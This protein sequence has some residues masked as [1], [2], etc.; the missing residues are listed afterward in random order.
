MNL[1]FGVLLGAVAY[2]YGVPEIPAMIGGTAP[3]GPAWTENIPIGGKVRQFGRD[4]QPYE[5][6]RFEDLMREVIFNGGQQNLSMLI[7]TPDGRDVWYDVQPSTRLKKITK[8]ASLG[9]APLRG[10]E[11]IARTPIASYLDP[12]TDV[13]LADHDKIIAVDGQKLAAGYELTEL[14][15]RHSSS[16][17]KLTVERKEESKDAAGKKVETTKEVQIVLQPRAMRDLGLIMKV[18]PVVAVRKGSP[19]AEAGFQVG[20]VIEMVDGQPVGDPLSLGQRLVPASEPA[21]SVEFTISRSAASG[22]PTQKTLTVTPELPR[23]YTGDMAA[24]GPAAIE[25]VGVAFEVTA[26]VAA[27]VPGSPAAKAGLAAGD[28]LTVAQFIAANDAAREREQKVLG[29]KNAFDPITLDNLTKNWNAVFFRLQDSLPDTRLKLTW[30]R[31]GKTQS[32]ELQSVTSDSF[33]DETRGVALY[34]ER[35]KHLAKNWSEALFL[36]YRETVERLKEVLRVLSGLLTGS[37]SATNL[38]GPIGI[39]G[40]AGSFANEGIP[41]LLIFLTMLSANLAVLNL[42]PI[43]ALDGGHLLFLAAE[44]VRGKPVDEKLQMKLTIAGVLCLLSLMVFA[45]AMDFSRFF[46]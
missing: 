29:D 11:V 15:A 24:G 32:G 12:T 7:R 37:I 2:W 40:A 13:P 18:G 30:T 20:D 5:H 31:G 3:G 41:M 10:L 45:T 17:L 39:I 8:R 14:L 9:V 38:S 42:L 43:P 16:P 23:Q 34:P 44:W 4:G 6:L 27:V 21:K 22:K 1:I 28:T 36:G 25:S 19:A 26:V 33:F 35:E 46:S